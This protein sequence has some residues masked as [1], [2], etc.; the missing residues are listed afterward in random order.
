MVLRMGDGVGAA[1]TSIPDGTVAASID[2]STPSY[3][4]H[5]AMTPEAITSLVMP[6]TIGFSVAAHNEIVLSMHFV[7]QG[8][9]PLTPK[10]KVNL[11]FAQNVQHEAA[12][13][14]S[15]NAGINVPEGTASGPSTQTVTGTC[16]APVG[17]Q[18]FLATT[19][20]FSRATSASVSY[21]SKGQATEIVHTGAAT[22]YA[23]EQEPGSGGD[24]LDRVVQL[25]GVR[26]N[27]CRSFM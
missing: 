13:I 6:P 20:T 11:L 21:V 5:T 8:C 25:N 22:S 10:I 4:L 14:I 24:W 12:L 16:Q 2:R 17:S 19:R 27:G 9:T 23:P 18:I 26:F 3:V 15:F 1:T 7:N